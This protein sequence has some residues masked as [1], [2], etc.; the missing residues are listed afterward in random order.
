MRQSACPIWLTGMRMSRGAARC[1]IDSDLA[2]DMT[3]S[4]GPFRFVYGPLSYLGATRV[5]RSSRDAPVRSRIAACAPECRY[6]L[7]SKCATYRS[8]QTF[9]S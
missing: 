3:S 4:V 1:S 2:V 5:I 7:A 9:T 8:C 6:P